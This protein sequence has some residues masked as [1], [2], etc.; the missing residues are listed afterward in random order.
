MSRLT[1]S[2]PIIRLIPSPL[3][4]FCNINSKEKLFT[5]QNWPTYV[6]H[7][8]KECIQLLIHMLDH[9]GIL[10]ACKWRLQQVTACLPSNCYFNLF[11]CIYLAFISTCCYPCAA[12]QSYHL[13]THTQAYTHMYSY[14]GE[15]PSFLCALVHLLSFTSV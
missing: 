15:A 10:E 12:C 1:S 8:V 2:Y 3:L 9:H 6:H 7:G 13:H 4:N 14:V 11:S 5:N